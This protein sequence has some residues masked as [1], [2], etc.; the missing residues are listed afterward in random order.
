MSVTNG[1]T[2][3]LGSQ[4]G[5]EY[6][7]TVGTKRM[8]ITKSVARDLLATIDEYRKGVVLVCTHAFAPGSG[9]LSGQHTG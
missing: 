2:E 1:I 6:I 7:M 5:L 9:L 3:A 8:R 4:F